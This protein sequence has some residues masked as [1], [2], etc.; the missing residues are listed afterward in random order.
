LLLLLPLLLPL[1]LLLLLCPRP[2]QALA[3]LLLLLLRWLL[4]RLLLLVVLVVVFRA[5]LAFGAGCAR[6]CCR[7]LYG[8]AAAG[9][10]VG[11]VTLWR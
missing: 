11:L 4:V 3:R 2:F 10:V 9:A 5:P 7:S 1:L 8:R 6:R